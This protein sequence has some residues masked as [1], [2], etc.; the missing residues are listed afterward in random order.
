MNRE[1]SYRGDI[2]AAIA[3]IFCDY[4]CYRHSKSLFIRF[5]VRF[6]Y[7]IHTDGKNNEIQKLMKFITQRYSYLGYDPAYIWAREQHN[8]HNQHYHCVLLLDGQK[9]YK[10]KQIFSYIEDKWASI[11]HIFDKG[12][13]ERC[14]N[15][16]RYANG[17]NIRRCDEGFIDDLSSATHWA[18]YLAKEFSK[19]C[20]IS[21]VRCFGMSRCPFHD[22]RWCQEQYPLKWQFSSCPIYRY[23]QGESLQSIFPY[24]PMQQPLPPMPSSS[25]SVIVPSVLV[26][27]G[28]LSCELNHTTETSNWSIMAAP[29]PLDDDFLSDYSSYE[30]CKRYDDEEEGKGRFIY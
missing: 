30:G 20:D 23:R 7:Q 12:L 3:N 17:V 11:T 9:V 18:L 4:C 5:D 10:Y 15:N 28:G 29:E 27:E 14:L 19:H 16:P 8:S 25:A 1:Y 2:V 22:C 26:N 6:P 24:T 21:R 13:I